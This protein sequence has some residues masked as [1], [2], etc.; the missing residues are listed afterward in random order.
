M[1]TLKQLRERALLSQSE[2]AELC[3]VNPHT[4]SFWE[5][6]VSRPLT[7]YQ[8]KLVEAL[9]CSA[10]DLLQALEETRKE[11]EQKRDP[12]DRAAA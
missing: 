7:R 11:H 4:I 8:R 3:G 5:R 2:L 9:H 1:P 12:N 10:D 6:G